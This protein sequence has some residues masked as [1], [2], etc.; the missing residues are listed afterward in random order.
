MHSH[1]KW[2]W[3]ENENTVN[4]KSASFVIIML[5][6]KGLTCIHSQKNAFWREFHFKSVNQ[7][8]FKLVFK[9]HGDQS[10]GI[11]L[12]LRLSS[13]NPSHKVGGVNIRVQCLFCLCS[14]PA[15][16]AVAHSSHPRRLELKLSAEPLQSLSISFVINMGRRGGLQSCT[17][18]SHGLPGWETYHGLAFVHYMCDLV[19][20]PRRLAFYVSARLFILLSII[21][22]VWTHTEGQKESVRDICFFFSGRENTL[23]TLIDVRCAPGLMPV[24][25]LII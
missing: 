10:Q 18:V 12:F 22:H 5:L 7:P 17:V 4:L 2:V 6:H 23:S 25:R 13:V 11:S 21:R 20:R 8:K 16:P 15:C 24:Q 9:C 1:L 19:M 14:F 3:D